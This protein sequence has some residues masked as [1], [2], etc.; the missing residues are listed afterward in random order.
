ML[1]DKIYDLKGIAHPGGYF[2]FK[3]IKALEISRYFYGQHPF[4]RFYTQHA[5]IIHRHSTWA[6]NLL[7]K[8]FIG[9]VSIP[10]I[11]KRSEAAM[12]QVSEYIPGKQID[13][14]QDQLLSQSEVH[15]LVQTPI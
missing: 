4:E 3:N 15:Y 9:F 13:S 8:R 14:D 12:S 7:D 10:K 6:M 2:I 11:F 1:E 5:D